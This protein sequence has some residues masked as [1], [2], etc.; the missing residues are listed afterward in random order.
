MKWN[1]IQWLKILCIY[2]IKDAL[3]EKQVAKYYATFIC[4]KETN[5]RVHNFTGRENIWREHSE[6]IRVFISGIWN[7]EKMRWDPGLLFVI[8]YALTLVEVFMMIK[9]YRYN[10]KLHKLK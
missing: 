7:E 1:T 2:D 10:K 4:K 9:H 3:S 6:L 8:T 5:I